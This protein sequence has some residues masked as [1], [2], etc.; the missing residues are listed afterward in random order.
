[1]R[2]RSGLRG[3]RHTTRSAKNPQRRSNSDTF[4]DLPGRVIT[5]ACTPKSCP[6]RQ[7]ALRDDRS[8]PSGREVTA[9]RTSF[10][11]WK[12]EYN[13]ASSAEGRRRSEETEL[14]ELERKIGRLTLFEPIHN[15]ARRDRRI[16]NPVAIVA[17]G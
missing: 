14:A 10:R 3:S 12:L 17:I 11:A 4:V 2:R 15:H 16:Q 1:M 9:A 13:S 6:P 5:P 7:A 8:K